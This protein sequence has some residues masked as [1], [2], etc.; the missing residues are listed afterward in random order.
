MF[1]ESHGDRCDMNW[2][3]S[4]KGRVQ[5]LR[6]RRPNM[7]SMPRRLE[8]KVCECCDEIV[9]TFVFASDQGDGEK[10]DG[11]EGK[12]SLQASESSRTL[13]Y[14]MQKLEVIW[15]EMLADPSSCL[16]EEHKGYQQQHGERYLQMKSYTEKL[17]EELQE[18]KNKVSTLTTS[19]DDLREAYKDKSRK[20][21]NWEKMVKALK[22]QNQ[23]PGQRV[24]SA[25]P[26]GRLPLTNASPKFANT[27]ASHSKPVARPSYASSTSTQRPVF[28]LPPQINTS[29]SRFAPGPPSMETS[30]FRSSGGSV[31]MPTPMP[32]SGHNTRASKKRYA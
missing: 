19:N 30:G 20:C 15:E 11:S 16:V 18:F 2:C 3:T 24:M 10:L 4:G 21:R 26:S 8:P 14:F 12:T 9:I 28:G 17:E 13:C 23:P 31:N 29:S 5:A 27:I 25:Q 6:R 32:H 22:S 7:P 1:D